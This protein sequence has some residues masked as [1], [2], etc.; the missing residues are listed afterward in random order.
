MNTVP[1]ANLNNL[2]DYSSFMLHMR[3]V[4]NDSKVIKALFNTAQEEWDRSFDANTDKHLIQGVFASP[5]KTEA[6][7][8]YIAKIIKL[9]MISVGTRL[10]TWTKDTVASENPTNVAISH[11][12]AAIEYKSN[13]ELFNMVATRLVG[14]DDKLVAFALEDDVDTQAKYL[15]DYMSAQF[16]LSFN[17]EKPHLT[18]ID[19]TVDLAS[20]LKTDGFT[21]EFF[22]AHI[23]HATKYFEVTG[24]TLVNLWDLFEKLD[25]IVMVNA[26]H[27][28]SDELYEELTSASAQE[29]TKKPELFTLDIDPEDSDPVLTIEVCVQ[30]YGDIRVVLPKD[31]EYTTELKM[32]MGELINKA[33]AAGKTLEIVQDGSDL[34]IV[35]PIELGASMIS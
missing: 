31:I 12:I 8:T 33:K 14:F 34:K 11:R 15:M 20:L 13:R 28:K 18:Y 23:H 16:D 29:L 35:P 26:E 5:Q 10:T 24:T 21:P 30:H 3:N 4:V 17:G 27:V 1:Q 7:K 22:N 2:L 25:V 6:I 19:Q 9:H 32:A